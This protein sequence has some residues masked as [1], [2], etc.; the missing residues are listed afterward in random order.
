MTQFYGIERGGV[1]VD[2]GGTVPDP[3]RRSSIDFDGAF[4]GV[5]CPNKS[6]LLL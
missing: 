5:G 1:L 6:R 2:S 3:D 4:V